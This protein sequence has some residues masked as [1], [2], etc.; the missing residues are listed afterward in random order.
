MLLYAP[1]FTSI[2]FAGHL[3]N[4]IELAAVGVG[5]ATT[6]MLL[7]SISLGV[8]LALEALH[9]QAFGS[10]NLELCGVYLNRARFI[11]LGFMIP[12]GIFLY[13]IVED[14]LIAM[15]QEL[16]VVEPAARYTRAI[17]PGILFQGLADTQK[18]WLI[19]M[20]IIRVP[21]IAYGLATVIHI[22]LC[23][24]FV[25][26]LELG[27]MGIAYALIITYL[28]QFLLMVVHTSFIKEIEEAVFLPRA[29]SFTGWGEYIA[30][31]VPAI[32]AVLTYTWS[33]E[34][35]LIFS[36]MIGSL[37]LAT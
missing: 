24:L 5:N 4:Q 18:K 25:F 19:L 16:E 26:T 31:A 6:T 20:R 13:F 1:I 17:I 14:F 33:Q 28:A 36:G 7:I 37:E 22:G 2:I 35:I 8:N 12:F 11:Q 29:D 10:G 3:D 23:Y 21:M 15:G 9:S 32:L 27:M 34:V 30:I